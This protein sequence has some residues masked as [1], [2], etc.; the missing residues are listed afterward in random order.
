MKRK[1][2]TFL[3][4]LRK[5]GAK[6]NEDGDLD[7]SDVHEDNV[8]N[9]F[10]KNA[11]L[12]RLTLMQADLEFEY[13]QKLEK[14]QIQADVYQLAVK[15]DEKLKFADYAKDAAE[16][17]KRVL[18]YEE[19]FQLDQTLDGQP[20]PKQKK[21]FTLGQSSKGDT[22]FDEFKTQRE[23]DNMFENDL[24]D[25]EFKFWESQEDKE[26]RIKQ[27]WIELKKKRAIRPASEQR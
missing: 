23:S 12:V 20:K 19:Y 14:M 2:K 5:F 26:L 24:L 13:P 1:A 10:E 17:R 7:L 22:T 9:Y 15:E 3:K 27:L 4:K 8:R 21:G 11:S 16:A 25:L 6:L 18:T